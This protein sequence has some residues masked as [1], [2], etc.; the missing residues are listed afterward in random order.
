MNALAWSAFFANWIWWLIGAVVAYILLNNILPALTRRTNVEL[1]DLVL[2]VL[3]WPVTLFIAIYGVAQS[4]PLLTLT[5]AY[6]AD[7]QRVTRLIWIWLVVWALLAFIKQAGDTLQRMAE[8]SESDLDNTLVPI[9]RSAGPMLIIFVAVLASVAW[10]LGMDLGLFVGILGGLSFIIAFAFQDILG[11]LFA[12]AY[13]LVGNPFRYGDFIRLEDGGIYRVDEIGLR[14]TVL[15]DIDKHVVLYMPNSA[16]ASLK[17]AN[18]T[19]PNVEVKT[20]I[21]V[22]VAYGSEPEM[23]MEIL[24]SVAQAHPHVLGNLSDKIDAFVQINERGSKDIQTILGLFSSYFKKYSD[25]LGKIESGDFQEPLEDWRE[26][27]MLARW[28]TERLIRQKVERLSRELFLFSAWVDRAEDGG[29]QPEEKSQIQNRVQPS[30]DTLSDLRTLMTLWMQL[31]QEEAL[32]YERDKEDT[33]ERVPDPRAKLERIFQRVV[34]EEVPSFA[35]QEDGK[36]ECLASIFVLKNSMPS[37]ITEWAQEPTDEFLDSVLYA[38]Q[39]EDYQ[40]LYASNHRIFRRIAQKLDEW[41]NSQKWLKTGSEFSLD[42]DIDRIRTNYV[43]QLPMP[44][45]KWKRPDTSFLDFG[46]S[47]LDFR[48]DFFIDDIVG[49]HFGREDDVVTDLRK[50]IASQFAKAGIEIP[51]P[52]Q[53][54]W[55]RNE[56]KGNWNGTPKK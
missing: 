54:V 19:K 47:S 50:E 4:A 31:A 39:L 51:F 32:N 48:L 17:I 8:R 14:A 12:G 24:E 34:N 33:S 52:Q 41:S 20:S 56:L 22:G 53:D 30:K 55:F 36:Q 38:T 23:V 25:G 9:L 26:W 43:E 6:A 37:K 7:V 27:L 3:K 1:D 44:I 42:D 5:E 15:Y 2:G 11:N 18:I 28:M 16:L 21:P 13:L 49:E 35:I 45:P 10:A 40:K 46:A 29:W